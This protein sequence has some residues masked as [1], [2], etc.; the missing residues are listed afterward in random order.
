MRPRRLTMHAFGPYAG[1]EV[2]DLGVLDAEGLFLI[3]G[4]TGAGKTFLLDAVTFALF[5]EVAGERTVPSLRSDFADP[6]AEPRVSLEFRT[7]AADWLV[8]RVPRHERARLRGTG[9]VSKPGGA[10]LSRRVG[11]GWEPVASGVGEVNTSVHELLGLTARQFQQV[12]L[13]PQGRFEEVLRAGSDKREELL[14]TLFDTQLY[15]AVAMHLDQRATEERAALSGTLEQLAQLRHQ[16]TARWREIV[17]P[18]RDDSSED[19][20]APEA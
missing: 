19:A 2:V 17:G 9:T 12:I 1:T 10:H 18:P 8:E 4:R 16:A 7:Q 11:D 14:K 3:H 13:L 6:Q 20:S 5:G 15:E